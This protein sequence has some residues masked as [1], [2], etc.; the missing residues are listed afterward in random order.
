M[1]DSGE[2]GVKM[3]VGRGFVERDE[4]ECGKGVNGRENSRESKET[5]VRG[6]C[7]SRLKTQPTKSS[8]SVCVAWRGECYHKY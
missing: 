6:R 5:H 2:D 7:E 4:R 8:A 3:R 1:D